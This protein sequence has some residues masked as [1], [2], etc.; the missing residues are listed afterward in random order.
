MQSRHPGLAWKRATQHQPCVCAATPDD[1]V[2]GIRSALTLPYSFWL[3][4]AEIW[5]PNHPRRMPTEKKARARLP[6]T[7]DFPS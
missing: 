1:F 7:R 5:F 3:H 2:V 4:Q 6:E